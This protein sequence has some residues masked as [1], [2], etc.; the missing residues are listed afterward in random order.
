MSEKDTIKVY[1][2]KAFTSKFMPSDDLKAIVQVE[3]DN[4]F[5]T[6]L[7]DMYKLVTRNVPASRSTINNCLFVT[8]GEA[9]MKIGS[10]QYKIHKNEILIVPAGQ[11][12]SFQTGDVNKGYICGFHSD[13]LLGKFAKTDLW[14]DFEFLRVWGN[15]KIE[16]DEQTAGFILNIFDRLLTE[17][18]KNGLRNQEIYQT[19]LHALFCEMQSAY[20]PLSSSKLISAIS[21]SNRFKEL[22]FSNIKSIHLVT[23]YASLLN[24]SPNHLNKTVKTITNKSPT[25]WIDEAILAEAKVLLC[26][27][28]FSIS[29]IASSVGFEDQSYFTRLFKKYENVTPTE[30]RKMID[31]S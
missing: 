30:F 12:F 28:Q 11:V 1:S 31:K 29:E 6:R 27:S 2:T 14:K 23:D 24:I 9:V 18:S 5:I 3:R 15:P 10:E 16:P 22:I 7:E 13:F 25:K 21:I 8:E 19:Y 20:K 26:Q 4:F 17:Y